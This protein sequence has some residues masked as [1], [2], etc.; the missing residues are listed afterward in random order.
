MPKTDK[1]LIF[2]FDSVHLLS[3]KQLSKAKFKPIPYILTAGLLIHKFSRARSVRL[4]VS[5]HTDEKRAKL[6]YLFTTG[7]TSL[8]DV[9]TVMKEFYFICQLNNV[10]LIETLVVNPFLKKSMME[11][12]GWK[13]VRKKKIFF[14]LYSKSLAQT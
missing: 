1:H 4:Y 5:I 6:I 14:K 12:D 2:Q 3:V 9:M 10:R 13:Y 7:K 8:Q 11:R